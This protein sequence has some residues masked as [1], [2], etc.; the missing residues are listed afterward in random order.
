M[1]TSL[2]HRNASVLAM[3]AAVILATGTTAAAAIFTVNTT[4]DAVD[5]NLTDNICDV[6]ASKAGPQ[7]TLRAAIAQANATSSADTI[8]F[9]I[10]ANDPKCNGTTH[11]CTITPAS[12]LPAVTAPVTIDGYTQPGASVNTLAVGDNAVLLIELNGT[13]A[14]SSGLTLAGVNG[15]ST[16]RGLVI[17]RF[18]GQF[19]D[20][21]IYVFSSNNVI[22]GCFIGVD[23]A[24]KVELPNHSGGG[25]R[26]VTGANN[27]IGGTTPAARNVISGNGAGNNGNIAIV[28][29]GTNPPSA[30]VATGTIIR[31]NYIG[32]N[33]AGKAAVHDPGTVGATT[34]IY[35]IVGTG[36]IIGGTDA[37]DGVLD[38]K[39]GARNL[40]SGNG[41]GIR[42]EE[43]SFTSAVGLL[44]QGNFIG[45]DAT[46]MTALP[47]GSGIIFGPPRDRTDSLL[48]LGGTA[49]GA[50]NV[51]S[52]NTGNGVYVVNSN[53]VMQGNRIG[54][55]LGGTLKLGNGSHGVE[56]TRA[57][58]PP[59]P[60]VQFTV[61]G[62]TP[63]ARNIISGSGGFGLRFFNPTSP[64]TVQG[65]YIGTK[66]DGKSDL[67][68][69]LNGIRAETSANIG[70]TVAGAGNVIAFNYTGAGQFSFPR[71]GIIF[72]S[73][74]FTPATGVSIRGNSIFSNGGLGIAFG[75]EGPTLND[76]GDADTGPNNRQNFPIL[77]SV[78]ATASGVDVTGMLNS[79]PNMTYRVEFFGNTELSP[80]LYGEGR[81]YLGFTN[82]TTNGNGNASF[83]AS[84]NAGE[85]VTS[86]ATDPAGNTS[87]FSQSTGQLLNIS[88]RLRVRTGDNVLIGGFIVAGSAP[89]KVIVR[90]I[91]PSLSNQVQ[92]P[93]A[94]PVLELH[95]SAGLLATNDNW[96]IDDQT[97]QSQQ[98]AIEATTIPPPNDLESALVRTLPANN[99]GYTA[100]LRGKGG[101]SGI[102][103]IEAYDLTD[104]ANSRLTNI[105]TRGLV[106]RGQ[107]VLIAGLIVGNGTTRVIVRAL[108]P[109]LPV[110]GALQDPLLELRDQNG[111]AMV[112]DNWK[113]TQQAEIAAT[114]IPPTRDAESAIVAILR[115]GSYTALV[116]GVN[117]TIGIALVEVYALP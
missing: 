111:N 114:G 14:S 112:N 71:G 80:S 99:T 36:T 115:P 58:S 20:A 1:K 78:K 40:I 81:T 30:P 34:G 61:G 50:G 26:V 7:C 104:G 19:I 9:S 101:A 102:G 93:L 46:G 62:T 116:R 5:T 83:V 96:K 100:V 70:G 65:N 35:V 75:T 87:E 103:V 63:A 117:D 37:D 57:G 2:A 72:P 13:N 17:N 51:I 69:R 67:G 23:P 24:G 32:T 39:V 68:N 109:S 88:T 44:V 107:D 60:V 77:T 29:D 41:T 97:R 25:I 79:R 16:V 91:G 12:G 66:G 89:K 59:F 43:T 53:V 74:T 27:V 10:P 92:S 76:L 86:T 38:G 110:T 22:T 82:V 49:A 106:E 108:G 90:G 11:V 55:D 84:V 98:A 48:T 54:T 113:Q 6:D 21:G 3:A 18:V 64:T 94:D 52:G 105:S 28:A 31:G 47:N 8:N 4:G 73:D 42:T 15:G 95:N 45:V 56:L 85:R 33:A